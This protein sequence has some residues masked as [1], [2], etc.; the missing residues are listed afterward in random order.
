MVE[1]PDSSGWQVGGIKYGVLNNSSHPL[2]SR[3]LCQFCTWPC[4]PQAIH[5]LLLSLSFPSPTP[6]LSLPPS[7]TLSCPAQGQ[8][9]RSSLLSR[10]VTLDPPMW[11][12]QG[13]WVSSSM[14]AWQWQAA[15]GRAMSSS[16]LTLCSPPIMAIGWLVGWQSACRFKH[17][18]TALYLNR[19]M[20]CKLGL[21]WIWSTD[22]PIHYTWL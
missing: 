6:H 16:S 12:H 1:G 15:A 13:W 10:A 20:D 11:H 2:I 4:N 5:H 17:S 7:L 19:L 9:I 21:I 14:Q 22:W 18:G 3:P 8:L